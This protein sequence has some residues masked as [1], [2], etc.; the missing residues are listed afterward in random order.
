MNLGEREGYGA[1]Q[2]TSPA[3]QL[4]AGLEE[5]HPPVRLE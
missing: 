2:G 1:S 4:R 3:E 5:S